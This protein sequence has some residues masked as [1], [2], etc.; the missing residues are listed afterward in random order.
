MTISKDG[1]RNIA[2]TNPEFISKKGTELC[3]NQQGEEET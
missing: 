1:A 3:N 2:T